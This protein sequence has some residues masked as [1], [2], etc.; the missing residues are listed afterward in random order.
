[1]NGWPQPGGW[2]EGRVPRRRAPSNA[3]PAQMK[4]LAAY[5]AAGGS[6]P[7]AAEFV[8][9]QPSTLKRHL[10][11]LR[12]RM[13]LTTE[14]VA[15]ALST[16]PYCRNSKRDPAKKIGSASAQ[17][18]PTSRIASPGMRSHR[19]ERTDA[20]FRRR[21]AARPRYIPAPPVRM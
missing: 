6:V 4:A 11:D 16:S 5:V 10:A 18:Q 2:H 7:E 17:I 21:Q 14:H 3:T 19:S 8:G 12:V 9:I 20:S 15:G 13:E 1:M